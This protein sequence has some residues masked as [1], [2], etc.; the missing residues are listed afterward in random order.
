[1]DPPLDDM[2]HDDYMTLAPTDLTSPNASPQAT[3]RNPAT[4]PA[5]LEL[6]MPSNE[7][8]FSAFGLENL[9]PN[10]GAREQ[11][12]TNT[13]P[14]INSNKPS[15]TTGP[16]PPHQRQQPPLTKPAPGRFNS[17]VPRRNGRGFNV[18][19]NVNGH[20]PPTTQRQQ[21]HFSSSSQPASNYNRPPPFNSSSNAAIPSAP[22]HP[23]AAAAT[24][25]TAQPS[26]PTAIAAYLSSI[27]RAGWRI[28]HDLGALEK[29][30]DVHERQRL[31]ID[32]PAP[33]VVRNSNKQFTSQFLQ[34]KQ[35]HLALQSAVLTMRGSVMEEMKSG[36][37]VRGWLAAV[38]AA[39]AGEGS[40]EDDDGEVGK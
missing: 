24:T 4:A 12:T 9:A 21:Q 6:E 3:P 28:A 31:P 2:H 39:T 36:E 1:M 32:R 29:L 17:Q 26:I 14:H 35:A 40:G 5:P 37:K 16:P 30:V 10:K 27:D 25:A 8:L 13:N 15:T 20:Q 38:S 19:V 11:Q 23:S 18:N 34:I 22:F 7:D 33:A